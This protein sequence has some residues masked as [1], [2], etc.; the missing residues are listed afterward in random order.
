MKL[1]TYTQIH[2]HNMMLECYVLSLRTVFLLKPP[3]ELHFL[4]FVKGKQNDV[5]K[6]RHV[7]QFSILMFGINKWICYSRNQ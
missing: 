3:Q 4:Q 7:I 5:L 6:L 1:Y 2:L